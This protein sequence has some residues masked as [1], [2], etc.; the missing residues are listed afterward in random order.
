MTDQPTETP[1]TNPETTTT[2]GPEIFRSRMFNGRTW[3]PPKGNPAGRL[4]LILSHPSH[5]DL[6]CRELLSQRSPYRAEVLAALQIAGISL[7]DVYVTAMVKYGI[8]SKPK[9]G[10]EQIEECAAQ[11]DFELE[12]VKPKL[13]MTL[14]AE[15]FKRLMKANRKQG[16]YLGEIGDSPYGKFTA[17][18][19][20]GMIIGQDPKLRP[21][22]R[23]NFL[24]AKKFLHDELNYQEFTYQ[25]VTDPEENR[26]LVADFIA[27]KKFYV[28]YDGEW[29]P[30]K[31]H[32]EVMHTLQYCC[33]PHHAIILDLSA[34][35]KTENLELLHTMKPLLEHPEL[36]RM[37]WAIRVDDKRLIQRGVAL[38]DETL[39]FDGMKAC[40]LFDSRLP[41]GLETGIK[42]FTNYPPYYNDFYRAL[43]R[44][45]LKKP[46]MVKLKFLE[47]DV[48]YR[49][50]AGDAVSHREAGLNMLV[51][52][53]TKV[54]KGELK[55]SVLDYFH[56]VYMPLSSYFTDLESHGL[57]ID[58]AKMTEITKQYRDKYDELTL[59]VAELVTPL[60]PDFNPRSAPQKKE[61]L[62][63]HL[64]LDPPYYTKAGKS[65]KAKAWFVKQRAQTQAL[66]APSTNNKCL[67]TLKFELTAALKTTPE[68]GALQGKWEIISALLALNRVG[69]F[70]TKFLNPQGTGLG[71]DAPVEGEELEDEELDDQGRPLKS[72][73]WAALCPD[74][75]IRPDFF[76]CLANFRSSSRPN[77]QN[78]ASK[79]LSHIPD[80]FVPGY[81]ELS[82]AERK[83]A[84][85]LI[86]ANVRHIFYP[87]KPDWHWAEVDVAGADLA[88]GAFL[89]GDQDYIKDI[90]AGGFHLTKAKEYFQDPN[91]TKDDYSRYVSS[92]AI[93]FRVS[94][95]ADLPSAAI[96]IQAEIFAESGILVELPAISYAL[97]TWKS[98]KRYMDYRKACTAS[99][100]EH[101]CIINARG[102]PYYF[103]DTENFGIRAGWHNESLAYPI[104][105][106][107]ALFM[108][109]LSVRIKNELKKEKLWN[110]KCI[111]VNSVHDA[112]YWIIHKD[113]LADNYFPEMCRHFF[114]SAVK[115]AT[116]DN[117]GMEMNVADRWK[118]KNTVFANETR[119]D[120]DK[121]VWVWK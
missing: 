78:P 51:G 80:I 21:T 87:G 96:P 64:Q 31:P 91:L 109:E 56:E 4:C 37:G 3:L 33:E 40:A 58:V 24:L 120:F 29:L 15:V 86:P 99:V 116:G 30:G 115:I 65:P 70:A 83:E 81:A 25:V 59:K 61:L 101:Q 89:S 104:A 34:D 88:I 5:D 110:T 100:D 63:T 102:I 92:K 98:Y 19:S 75:R 43:E 79:V 111:P 11:L 97:D 94:Y 74:N 73:Y 23:D 22:F 118:G 121:K 107:L 36:K 69:V 93:T 54:E 27:R 68:D 60:I 108:W 66:Y 41:K 12:L 67:A 42:K 44:H 77:V 13:I 62:Y 16:D 35:G 46:E 55:R 9:P 32:E 17:N 84:D 113:L 14:G 112:S 18:F 38:P 85:K 1:A 49:Y 48:F 39:Y 76:E 47:P 57:P 72:S 6:A 45:K 106:E 50:C 82:K 117:L 114:T 20:P 103:E 10:K 7:D 119:W 52:L 26:K 28:G 8:G 2:F 90:R 53:E 71:T 105:S 95:T